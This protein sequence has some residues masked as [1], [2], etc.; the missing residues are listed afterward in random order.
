MS[1]DVGL[2]GS[3]ALS[4]VQRLGRR[5]FI[6]KAALAATSLTTALVGVAQTASQAHAL[7]ARFFACCNLCQP[8]INP[9]SGACCWTW[10]CCGAGRVVLCTECYSSANDCGP[11]CPSKCSTGRVLRDIC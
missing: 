8:V 1:E 10:S 7:P 6:R 3:G 11:H 9:C 4:L 2:Q 5:Q